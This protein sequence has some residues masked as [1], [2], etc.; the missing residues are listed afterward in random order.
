MKIEQPMRTSA[1][2]SDKGLYTIGVQDTQFILIPQKNNTVERD[3]P[4]A[5]SREL[6][7]DIQKP[8]NIPV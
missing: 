7:R 1:P 3:F 6:P 4:P 8:G 5:M 2:T